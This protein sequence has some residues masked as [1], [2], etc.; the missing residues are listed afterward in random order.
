MVLAPGDFW[1]VQLKSK[2]DAAVL[3]K[4]PGDKYIPDEAFAIVSV[5]DR[6][7][8]DLELSFPDCV[9]EWH[10]IEKQLVDWNHLYRSGKRLKIKMELTYTLSEAASE[11]EA[12]SRQGTPAARCPGGR[13]TARSSRRHITSVERCVP[14]L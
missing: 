1:E 11:E 4:L 8:D 12:R 2:V 13:D 7:E 3:K 10:A 5:N 6:A 9:I 14:H